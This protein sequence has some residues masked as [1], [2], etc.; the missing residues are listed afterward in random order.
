VNL[1]GQ[2]AER[3]GGLLWLLVA[4]SQ[5]ESGLHSGTDRRIDSRIDPPVETIL[6]AA[7]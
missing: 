2:L 6:S 3:A 5:T 4:H 1:G 7:W